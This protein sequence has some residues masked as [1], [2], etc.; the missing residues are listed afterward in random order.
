[1]AIR[2]PR[3]HMLPPAD[4][5][6]DSYAQRSYDP[7]HAKRL[8]DNWNSRKLGVLKGSKRSDDYVYVFDGQ[9]R[10]GALR[11]LGADAPGLVPVLVYEGLSVAEEAEMFVAENAEN[12]KPN[13]IDVFRL[14]VVAGD[15][16]A[17]E[18]QKVL[19][20]H[21]LTVQFGYTAN[22]IASVSALRWLHAMDG[23][24]LIHQ[25]L[26]IVENA[27]GPTNRDA[28][29]GHLLKALGYVLIKAKG[30]PLDVSSLQDKL[31]ASGKPSL[32]VGAA[33]TYRIATKQALW[34]Q[35]AQGIVDI[36]NHQRSSRRVTL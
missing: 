11:N 34:L 1:M 20:D 12:R 25:V 27:W 14:Q 36:Y 7:R 16:V 35:V 13:P 26:D 10:L 4:L 15:P 6:V 24:R 18:I 32:I 5:K 29:D 30:H 33:R 21:G 3:L 19:D 31:G 22:S 28:R 17:T 8:S 2:K 23:N 9:H